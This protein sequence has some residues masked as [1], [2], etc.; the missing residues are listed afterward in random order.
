MRALDAIIYPPL[1]GGCQ[2]PRDSRAAILDAG[3]TIEAEERI[4]F[5][6]SAIAPSTPHIHGAARRN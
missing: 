5:R 6:P 2:S 3:V 4:A 1:A